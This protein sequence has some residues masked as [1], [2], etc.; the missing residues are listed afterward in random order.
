MYP[1][2]MT[3]GEV[4]QAA[5]DARLPRYSGFD[6]NGQGNAG[7]TYTFGAQGCEIR[8]EKKTG[9]VTI[10]HFASCFDVGQVVSPK[11]IRGQ[12]AGG[13]LMAIGAALFEVLRFDKEGRMLNPHYG[14]YRMPK[15]SDAPLK[16]TIEFAENPDAIGPFG[17]RALG[18]H[19]VIG[20]APAILNAIHDAIGTDFKRIPVVPEQILQAISNAEGKK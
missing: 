1:N 4:A 2:G 13:V 9:K 16:S 7:V 10:D 5:S 12:V 17:A 19:P 18:E 3:V 20:V 6:E 15:A 14:K 8:I 11:Q